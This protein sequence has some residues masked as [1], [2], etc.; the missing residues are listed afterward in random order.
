M[1]SLASVQHEDRD[2]ERRDRAAAASPQTAAEAGEAAEE[3]P[4]AS[5]GVNT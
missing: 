5:G 4:G 3:R 1:F 2:V